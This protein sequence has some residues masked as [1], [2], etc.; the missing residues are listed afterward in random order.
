[1]TECR[2]I[3]KLRIL[4]GYLGE[5]SQSDWW[6][7]SF[8]SRSGD[9]FISPVFGKSSGVAKAVGVTEAA[10]RTHDAA[11][12]IGRAFHLFRLPETREQDIHRD[13]IASG[14]LETP[15]SAEAALRELAELGGRNV[16][17]KPG[18][19]CIG[20]VSA[21]DGMDW[22]AQAASHY[23]AA[24]GSGVRAFPYFAG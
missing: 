13:L 2:D 7:S 6:P 12:G 1:M 24:F 17:V 4:V 21:L 19:T 16:P 15:E 3:L 10:R 9:A 23:R 5:Q 22:I 18:P 14:N 20:S 11:I 8:L